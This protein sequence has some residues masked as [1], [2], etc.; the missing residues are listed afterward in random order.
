MKIRLEML[1]QEEMDD[2]EAIRSDFRPVSRWLA[3]D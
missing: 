3:G 2:T 1:K